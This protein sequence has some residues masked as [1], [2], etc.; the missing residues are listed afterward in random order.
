MSQIGSPP[1]ETGSLAAFLVSTLPDSERQLLRAGAV[2]RYITRDLAKLTT[3]NAA[4][5]DRLVKH[6]LLQAARTG[7]G[8]EAWTMPDPLR[9]ALLREWDGA[10]SAWERISRL[11]DELESIYASLATDATRAD[12]LKRLEAMFERALKRKAVAVG[13]AHD[14]LRLLDEWP[15]NENSESR[16]LR[17][18]LTPRLRRHSRALRDREATEGYFKRDFERRVVK[19]LLDDGDRWLLHLH[20]P[21]GRG[22]SMFLKNLLGRNC[23]RRDIPVAWIDFDHI[24]RLGVNTTQPWR[25]LLTLARQL[26]TQLPHSPFQYMLGSYGHLRAALHAEALPR[27]GSALAIE[28]EGQVDELVLQAATEVPRKFRTELATALDKGLVIIAVDTV[29]NVQHADGANLDQVLAALAEVRHGGGAGIGDLGVPGLRVIVSGRF[30]LGS[31][32]VVADGSLHPRSAEF[33]EHF[34]GPKTERTSVSSINVLLGKQS[35]SLELPPF[36]EA[37]AS[38]YLAK[39]KLPEDVAQAIIRRSSGNALKLALFRE[40]VEQRPSVTAEEIDSWQSVELAYLVTR[41]VDRIADGLVQWMLRWGALLKVL[42]KEGVDQIIWPALEELVEHG[43]RYDDAS[44]D[45]MPTPGPGVV[46]WRLPSTFDVTRPSAADEAWAKL[47]RYAARSSWVSTIEDIPNALVF[48][49]EVRDP[50]RNLLRSEGNPVFDDIHRR[51]FAYWQG[52]APGASGRARAEALRGMIFHAYELA[53]D[54]SYGDSVWSSL[55]NDRSLS[56]SDRSEVSD[57]LLAVAARLKESGRDLPSLDAL[58]LAHLERGEQLVHEACAGGRS[59]DE[60]ALS[61]HRYGITP[62]IR[63]SEARRA[64]FLDAAMDLTLGLVEEAWKDLDT[65]LHHPESAHRRAQASLELIA[66][67]AQRLTPPAEAIKTARLLA[68]A[69]VDSQLFQTAALPLA[70]GL[71]A[72]EKW[73]QALEVAQQA[74]AAELVAR[75]LVGLGRANEVLVSPSSPTLQRAEAALLDL[76]PARALRELVDGTGRAVSEV[77]GPT[78]SLLRGEAHALRRENDPARAALSEAASGSDPVVALEA[79]LFLARLMAVTGD[80]QLAVAI[81]MR[82]PQRPDPVANIRAQAL[83]AVVNRDEISA[84]SDRTIRDAYDALARLA[85]VPP[86]VRVELEVARLCVLGPE[87][88]F[89][90]D[91]AQALGVIDGAAARLRALRWLA[92]VPAPRVPHDVSLARPLRSLTDVVLDPR[93]T[94]ATLLLARAELERVLGDELRAREVLDILSTFEVDDSEPLRLS[95]EDARHRLAE[96]ATGWVSFVLDTDHDL[97]F[98][99]SSPDD[100]MVVQISAVDDGSVLVVESRL[101]GLDGER[102]EVSDPLLKDGPYALAGASDAIFE[103]L[104][105]GL[106]LPS[107][108]ER[109]LSMAEPV[110]QLDIRDDAAAR[111]PWELARPF[112][113]PLIPINRRGCVIR[114]ARRTARTRSKGHVAS[115]EAYVAV[116]ND[117]KTFSHVT[118]LLMELYGA[119]SRA[120][121]GTP[122]ELMAGASLSHPNRRIVHLV[123]DPVER[124]RGPA[125][126]LTSGDHLTPERL[127]TAIDPRLP[128]LLI[129]DLVLA[130]SGSLAAEQLMLANDFCWNLVRNAPD[131]SVLCGVFTDSG[132]HLDRLQLLLDG[133]RDARPLSDVVGRLQRFSFESHSPYLRDC[134]SLST[135]A[136]QQVFHLGGG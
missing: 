126:E 53:S 22:K 19:L 4:A 68:D 111:W 90:E 52:V 130:P 40:Y 107:V 95:V 120:V 100:A 99:P 86:S 45:K 24:D 38:H 91:L 26:D 6:P 16:A 103:V 75:A 87:P 131:L 35:I 48:H 89:L 102:V 31:E 119:L 55:L 25:L 122:Y 125:L 15:V 69:T 80:R 98:T 66:K 92:E 76:R 20:A 1:S 56:R 9:R 27:Q 72:T 106:A 23:P 49:P 101:A 41:V 84:G 60:A 113:H 82:S 134:Y 33:R 105:N 73:T 114:A 93:E 74:E 71:L 135:D 124:R 96:D 112:G 97:E 34:L 109:L 47:L 128:T 94:A 117:R 10:A 136:P 58:G 65:A 118:N 61:T 42:T 51:A 57:E 64:T 30:D 12:G 81:L 123:A 115:P 14:L 110:L 78:V 108:D 85:W 83:V 29:E 18:K 132:D 88:E 3:G 37:E 2:L 104:G 62:G 7:R 5:A 46:R 44:T 67:W 21:G 43:G 50:L 11:G 127:A 59:V 133:L 121:P 17:D 13:S 129:L 32:V 54:P 39:L 36:S 116:L 77:A 63:I 70:R 79:T 8:A 28:E